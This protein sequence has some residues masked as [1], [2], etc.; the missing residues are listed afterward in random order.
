MNDLLQSYQFLLSKSVDDV[1]MPFVKRL[2][3]ALYGVA[4]EITKYIYSRNRVTELF[5]LWNNKVAWSQSRFIDVFS[6]KSCVIA[7]SAFLLFLRRC[8]DPI[9]TL[10]HFFGTLYQAEIPKYLHS[11]NRVTKYLP[12]Q[13]IKLC[14][15]K[16][17]LLVLLRK[18]TSKPTLLSHSF[19]IWKG[20]YFVTRFLLWRYLGISAW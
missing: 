12:F 2:L 13:I 6:Q 8:T 17:G 3:P 20:K 4:T 10:A 15:S 7:L 5:A 18:S 9:H 1:R 19:I 16:V 14:D 11:R